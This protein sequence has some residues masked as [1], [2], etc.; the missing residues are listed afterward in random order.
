VELIAFAVVLREA[1]ELNAGAA[2]GGS[3][4]RVA[5]IS[6]AGHGASGFEGVRRG[7]SVS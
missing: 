5:V 2:L 7:A 3:V 6:E 1:H 4:R